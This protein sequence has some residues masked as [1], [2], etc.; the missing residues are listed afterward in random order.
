MKEWTLAN[1]HKWEE[2]KPQWF[3][4]YFKESVPDDFV[5]KRAPLEDLNLESGGQ[6][7]RLSSFR[8][9]AAVRQS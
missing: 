9:V 6:R 4:E 2:E 3:T 7:Q 1:W 8:G 5:P